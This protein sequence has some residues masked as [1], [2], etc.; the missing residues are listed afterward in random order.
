MISKKMY[1]LGSKKSTIRSIFEYGRARAKVVGEENIYDF[2]LGNPNVPTPK[3]ITETMIDILQNEDPCS[4]HGYTVAQG[5]PE[6]RELLAKSL[7]KRFGTNFTGKNL[8]MTAGAAASITI[9]FKALSEENDEFITFAPYFPEYKCFVESTGAELKVVPAK[10]DDFQ[11]NFLEF[12]KMINKNTKGIIVNSPNNPSGAVYSEETIIKLTNLLREKEKEYGHPIFLIADEPY[13]EVAYNNVLIPYL[14]KYYDNTLVCYSYSK[15]FSLPGER[16]GYIVI[17]DE[18]VDFNMISASIGGAARVLTHVNA[19]ALFQKVVARCAD[20][21]SDIS[22]YEKNKELL[23]NGLIE[24]GFE[25]TNPGGAFYLFPKA[26]EDDEVAFCERA[27]KYDLLLVPG[28]D[29]GCPGY[30]RASYC[31]STE[32]IKKSLPLFKKLAE[33]YKK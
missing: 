13:R 21:P 22:V 6:C 29:F 9:C 10:V 24:A 14:P 20:M 17:P 3:F 11:I 5:D 27:K 31:I 23:Y 32:T 1:E 15:S 8:F 28:G 26:L 18:I 12:E 16:I 33:E 2:S 7:N 25:C 4:I 19:P 30:F